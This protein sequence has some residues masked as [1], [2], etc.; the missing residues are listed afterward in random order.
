M[1]SAFAVPITLLWKIAQEPC[2]AGEITQHAKGS[3]GL[4]LTLNGLQA[5][6]EGSP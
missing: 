6:V 5:V 4:A 1:E 2:M 3:C